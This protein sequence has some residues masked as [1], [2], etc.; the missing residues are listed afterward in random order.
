MYIHL[1]L[2]VVESRGVFVE[3][4]LVKIFLS[5][6]DKR[7]LDLAIPRITFN[8]GSKA[9]LAQTFV[10]VEKYNKALCQYDAIDIV[11]WMMDVSKS[12]KMTTI[13]SSLTETQLEKT[14]NC[15]KCGLTSSNLKP[16]PFTIVTSIRSMEQTT[17]YTK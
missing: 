15:W 17:S 11:T 10:E 2:L 13:K 12:K 4:Q 16:C 7:L 6:I 1:A 9:I 5:K 3:S 8:Y 14:M